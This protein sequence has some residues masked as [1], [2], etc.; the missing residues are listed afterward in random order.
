MP[1]RLDPPLYGLSPSTLPST[2]QMYLASPMSCPIQHYE[3]AHYLYLDH[4][5]IHTALAHHL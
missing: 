5:L 1:P 3:T 2:F 4:A